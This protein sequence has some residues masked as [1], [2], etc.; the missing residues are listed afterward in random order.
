MTR[1]RD[2]GL[3]GFALVAFCAPEQW[4]AVFGGE[5]R[6][7]AWLGIAAVLYGMP[8]SSSAF[9]ADGGL[10]RASARLP[11][12]SLLAPGIA[13]VW[14][15]DLALGRG[16]AV[17]TLGLG[18]LLV[19]L[20]AWLAERSRS[21]ERARA[22]AAGAWIF[23]GLGPALAFSVLAQTAPESWSGAAG[24]AWLAGLCVWSPFFDLCRGLPVAAGAWALA[25]GLSAGALA[26]VEGLVRAEADQ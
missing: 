17:L 15:R 19:V 2:W 21:T 25:L 9:F 22:V 24:N 13:L 18:A 8:A 26:L 12:L 5:A 11:Q 14:G 10:Q 1:A 23:L 20:W 7:F 16:G 4:D 6:M 3:L